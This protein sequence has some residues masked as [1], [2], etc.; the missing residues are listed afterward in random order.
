MNLD[1]NDLI[2]EVA[3]KII[4]HWNYRDLVEIPDAVRNVGSHVQEIYLKWNK[5]KSLPLW[6]SD[7]SNV[8]NLYL[9]GNNIEHLPDSLRHMNNLAVLDLSANQ[10]KEL[11]I[12]LGYLKNLRSLLLNQNFITSLPQSM[13]QLKNLER[14]F[15]SGNRIVALPEWLGAL[16]VL[17]ELFV[18]N[19]LLEEIPNRLTLSNSLSIISVCSNKLSYL[20]LNG[21]LSAPC[22]RF[23]SN[24]CLNYLSLPVLYQLM[25]KVQYP[26]SEESGNAIAHGCFRSN[27]KTNNCNIKTK[28]LLL[29]KNN[30]EHKKFVIELPRQLL[31]IHDIYENKVIS[32][33][34]LSLRK[35]Y[36][37]RFHHTLDISWDPPN[38]YV[39]QNPILDKINFGIDKYLKSLIPFGLLLNG[40]ISICMNKYCNEPI[41]SEAWILLGSGKNTF[42]I[43]TIV[44]LCCHRCAT[45][46]IK[47]SNFIEN[48]DIYVYMCQD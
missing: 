11:P 26:M 39:K 48:H 46:F 20:P 9:Y 18:D 43:P 3:E 47:T 25:C 16:P 36:L 29:S 15:L 6:I 30:S 31:V 10:L 1:L 24:P 27:S 33:W 34:E 44:I 19:N 21:F 5:L 41:F 14:L 17:G 45:E 8:T 13:S 2:N 28:L 32:L 37:S 12:C 22:I 40:P 23:N 35:V 4:L 42:A 7:F 38:V